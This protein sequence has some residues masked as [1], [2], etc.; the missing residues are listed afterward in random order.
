MVQEVDAAAITFTAKHLN[1]TTTEINFSS[2][3]N[4]TLNAKDWAIKAHSCTAPC[5]TNP[6]A[7]AGVIT[8]DYAISNV[9]NGTVPSTGDT[10]T[11][12]VAFNDAQTFNFVNSSD[13]IYLRHAAIP[14]DATY[15]INYTHNIPL[16]NAA[17]IGQF[18]EAKL[19]GAAPSLASAHEVVE[20]GFNA[21]AADWM[22]PEVVS[23]IK[24]GPKKIQILMS[25]SV[26]NINS[27]GLDFTLSGSHHPIV[28][29]V[30]ASNVTSIIYLSTQNL[31]EPINIKPAITLSY[32][33]TTASSDWVTDGINSEK[34]T[35]GGHYHGNRL[36]NFTGLS[37]T[38]PTDFTTDTQR[39]PPHIHDEV[40]VVINSN[41]VYNLKIH[42]DVTSNILARVGDTVSVT[43]SIGDDTFLYQISK[44]IL[45]TNY[46]REPSDMNKYYSTNHDKM[47]QT[48]LS[49]YEW[50]HNNFDQNYDYSGVI[51]WDEAIVKIDKRI[52]TYHEYVGPLLFD[53]NELFVTY[54][55]TFDD[56][57]PKSQV[58]IKINDANSNNFES[59]L[60]FT[61]EVLP[62]NA[63]TPTKLMEESSGESSGESNS[64]E[65]ELVEITLVANKDS[66]QNGDKVMITGQ[67]KNYDLNSMKGNTIL[68]DVVSPENVVLS[69][70]HIGP[71][72]DGSFYFTTF[73]MDTIWKM[74]GNYIL[75]VNM[76]SL[77]Q[78]MIIS[79]DNAEFEAPTFESEV[80]T[81]IP[82]VPEVTTTIPTVP[83]TIP[84]TSKSNI[85][86]GPGTED[87]NG[88]C[89]VIQTEKE[90]AQGGG[91]LIA[92]ATYGSEM[93]TE[94][95]QLRELRDNQLLNTE[96]G[97]AFM[98]GFNELYYSFSPI[99]ADYERE[100][101][102]FKEAVKIAITP[103]ISSLAIMENA[104][105]ESEVLGLGLS[106][107][108]LNLGMYLGVPAVMII[109]IRKKF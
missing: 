5:I 14:T 81:T 98:S 80:T 101:P 105:S 12:K 102:L 94:V 77:K 49:V 36:L 92:T 63:I 46:D 104:N 13:T 6:A 47:G 51:S 67:I 100:N 41:E 106:V 22:S 11:A 79:Y 95:Q 87:L 40:S 25:E 29:D 103:M 18:H 28:S 58:G 24:T 86:C 38:Y 34:Y 56:V 90:T 15:F 20:V 4:G 26:V 55:M 96:F 99:I 75:N 35:P 68:Y 69:S 53:E 65:S 64:P 32:A 17:H 97:T 54:S 88:I 78:T 76:K 10:V 66:Y 44:A 21:T 19:N 74:D 3:V 107:I 83:E 37:V 23:A 60:P 70:G 33:T 59:F 31:I 9:N 82:T 93:A 39:F 62:N 52:E 30:I 71:N 48:G 85:M 16:S 1:S 84:K 91:C 42:D 61:L 27:T 8:S 2:V 109:G 7:V 57:M 45:I 89:Q 43:V 72:S 108:M 50:N 73:A